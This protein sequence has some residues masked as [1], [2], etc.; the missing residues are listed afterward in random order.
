METFI[1]DGKR[2]DPLIGLPGAANWLYSLLVIKPTG[3]VI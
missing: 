2:S 1:S 3:A